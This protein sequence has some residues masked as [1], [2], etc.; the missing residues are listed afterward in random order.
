MD[1]DYQP[2]RQPDFVLEDLDIPYQFRDACT[3][4]YVAFLDC[5]RTHSPL[6]ESK[7][8]MNLPILKLFSRC[9]E[10]RQ[11]WLRCQDY[12]EKEVFEDMRRAFLAHRP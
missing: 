12:R 3:Q 9:R 2:P 4:D 5:A 1:R 7:A 8:G 11:Q 10:L 6:L